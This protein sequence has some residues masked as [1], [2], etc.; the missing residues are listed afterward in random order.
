MLSIIC[1]AA[2]LRLGAQRI[3]TSFEES[4]KLDGTC[5]CLFWSR[6][7]FFVLNF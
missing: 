1:L 3:T 5:G 4:N 7:L 2:G 6:I